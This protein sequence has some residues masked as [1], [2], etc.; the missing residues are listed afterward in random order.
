VEASEAPCTWLWYSSL[1]L[2]SKELSKMR[3]TKIRFAL[4]I[5]ALAAGIVLNFI[6]T[7]VATFG[8]TKSKASVTCSA[9][10]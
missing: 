1:L 5:L 10:S 6:H 8:G 2:T 7:S 4:T 3:P 9:R